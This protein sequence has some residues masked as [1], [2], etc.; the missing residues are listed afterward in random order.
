MRQNLRKRKI[1]FVTRAVFLTLC[2]V[3][4]TLPGKAQVS[5]GDNYQVYMKEGNSQVARGA[6]NVKFYDDHGPSYAS[7]G[8]T[9]YW[10]RWYMVNKHYT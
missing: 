10:D 9:N 8:N 3:L 6:T 1:R 5:T 2:S 4:F 7:D